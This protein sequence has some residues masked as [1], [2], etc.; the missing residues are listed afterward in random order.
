MLLMMVAHYEKE[1]NSQSLPKRVSNEIKLL[2]SNT[3]SEG[4]CKNIILI[5]DDMSK[6]V[7]NAR[8]TIDLSIVSFLNKD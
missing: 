2:V 5:T 7:V 4:F 6:S 3:I 8:E 1:N